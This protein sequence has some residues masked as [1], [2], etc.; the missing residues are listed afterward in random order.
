M[1][2]EIIKSIAKD[3]I[4][5]PIHHNEPLSMLQKL[6]EKFQYAPLLNIA[7][8]NQNPYFQLAYIAGFLM[9]EVS[10]NI[11]RVL[12]PFNPILGET[13]EFID[14]QNK[15]RYFSEQVS[16]HPP[17]SAFNCESEKFVIFGDSRCTNKFKFLKGEIELNHNDET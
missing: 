15:F 12:K 13:F 9:G 8:T 4:E 3:K 14:N 17:I 5:L 7:S 11:N 10:L 16:H 1:F 6:C 2:S